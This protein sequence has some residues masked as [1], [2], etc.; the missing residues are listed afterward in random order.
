MGCL[1]GTVDTHEGMVKELL[2]KGTVLFLIL[3]TNEEDKGIQKKTATASS[4]NGFFL[5][6]WKAF[7]YQAKEWRSLGMPKNKGKLQ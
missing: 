4:K 7:E 1:R 5:Y 2:N 3:S 6:S